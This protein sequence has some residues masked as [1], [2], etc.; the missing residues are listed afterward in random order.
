MI[1]RV[2]LIPVLLAIW[3]GVFGWAA[4][5][6]WNAPWWPKERVAFSGTEFQVQFGRGSRQA[7]GL[8]VKSLAEDGTGLQTVSLRHLRTQDYPVLSYRIEDFPDTLELALVFRRTDAPDDVQTVSIA[9]PGRSITSIDLSTLPDWHGEITEIGFAEYATGQ[10]VPPSLATFK[11]FR[12]L[13]A[14]LQSRSW[15]EVLPRLRSDWFGYR[16]WALYS[17]SALGPQIASLQSSWMQ[18]AVVF[19]TVLSLIAAGLILRWSRRRVVQAVLI[20]TVAVWVALDLRWLDD[21][22]AKHRVIE[23]M[24]AGKSWNEREQLQPDEDTLAA[25]HEVLQIAASQGIGRVMVSCDSTYTLLRF[26]YFLSPLNAVPLSLSLGAAPG[27][28]PQGDVLI[29]TFNSGA[30]YDETSHMLTDGGNSIRAEQVTTKGDL[31]IYRS[32]GAAP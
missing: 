17:I 9:A 25:A 19:G 24:F 11:P 8:I 18:P 6:P 7:D 31:H 21:F 20:A 22:S 12:I 2:L 10:L 32:N 1:R 13:D 16:P 4:G 27:T 26:I 15:S 14:S 30:T 28:A 3:L 23:Q 29:A 5:L